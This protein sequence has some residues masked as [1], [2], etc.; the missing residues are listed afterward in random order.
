MIKILS[1]ISIFSFLLLSINC[2]YG[3]DLRDFKV[4][5]NIDLVPER[6]YVN[7][8]CEDQTEISKWSSFKKCKKNSNNNYIIK[9]EYDERFAVT[10]EYEGT[11]VAGHPVLINVA[12]DERG[13]LQE[14]N[15]NT[16]PTAPFYFRKQSHLLW[17]RVKSRYG[18]Q[19]WECVEGKGPM[20]GTQTIEA[21]EGG[22][23]TGRSQD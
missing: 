12:I 3:D 19:G 15:I 2:V 5:T 9:F 22:R 7:L 14:I 16:D 23:R 21:H 4:G 8:K 13:I 20:P 6:G 17:L 18:S 11:Q 10:E 1:T